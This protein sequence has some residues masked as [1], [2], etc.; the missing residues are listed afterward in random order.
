M[1]V[2]YPQH[3]EIKKGTYNPWLPDGVAFPKDFSC[4]ISKSGGG[5]SFSLP[6][7]EPLIEPG[8]LVVYP[9]YLEDFGGIIMSRDIDLGSHKVTYSGLSWRGMLSNYITEIG[10]NDRT[11][12]V[13]SEV[14]HPGCQTQLSGTTSGGIAYPNNGPY[15][16]LHYLFDFFKLPFYV[17]SPTTDDLIDLAADTVIRTKVPL[18]TNLGELI[19]LFEKTYG[20]KVSVFAPTHFAGNEV[21]ASEILDFFLGYPDVYEDNEMATP[22]IYDESQMIVTQQFSVNE[23]L[24]QAT[25]TVMH[26]VANDGTIKSAVNLTNNYPTDLKY[27]GIKQYSYWNPTDR[28]NDKCREELAN[29]RLEGGKLKSEIKISLK[30]R[31]KWGISSAEIGDRIKYHLHS[32][33]ADFDQILTGKKLEIINGIP[34]ITYIL[35]G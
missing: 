13:E 16:L 2:N 12:T 33:N 23:M 14:S 35:G 11:I 8:S 17:Y 29:K 26:Y 7:T 31:D 24:D 28:P 9:L 15:P 32:V 6:L 34:F 10:V 18:G 4:E 20:Y 27:Y 21:N 25:N 1:E 22:L 3:I 30:D 5:L 19:Q